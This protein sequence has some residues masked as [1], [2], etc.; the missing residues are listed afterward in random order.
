MK[1]ISLLE[2]CLDAPASQIGGKGTW[3]AKLYS[4][5]VRIPKTICLSTAA[6]SYF[7]KTQGLG[8]KIALELNR[9]EFKDMRWEEIWDA[10]LRIRNLF[11]QSPFPQDLNDELASI[12]DQEFGNTPVA[13]R[14]SAPDEDQQ[15]N[16]FAGLHDSFL[17]ISGVEQIFHSIKKVW[18]SL[19]SDR[20]LLYRKELALS[21]KDSSMAVAI[22]Q[23]IE[24]SVS[25]I[26]FTQDP[27][28]EQKMT[29]EAVHGLNQGLVDGDIEPDRWHL[30]KSTRNIE[31]HT[32]PAK[33]IKQAIA[34]GRS[35]EISNLPQKLQQ[36]PPLGKKEVHTLADEMTRLA[37]LNGQPLDIEW[38]IKDDD[39]YILQSRPI[40]ALR[41]LEGK[42]KDERSWYLSLHRTLENLRNLRNTIEYSML[43]TMA[44]EAEKMAGIDLSRLSPVELADEIRRRQKQSS[45]WTELYWRD[46]IPFAHGIRLFGEVYNDLIV[47]QDSHE[48]VF[49]LRGENMLSL[50]RNATIEELAGML[51]A[52][53]QLFETLK[54]SGI[55]SVA[56]RRFLDLCDQF[57]AEFGSYFSTSAD[58]VH[59]K[60]KLLSKVILEYA[61][62]PASSADTKTKDYK[63]LEDNFL[64][65]LSASNYG[66]EAK[67]FLEMARASY[68]IRDDDNIYL[69]K[70]EEQAG[71]AVTVG[72]RRLEQ[73][74]TVLPHNST[75]EDIANLLYGKTI[76]EPSRIQP[77]PQE[78]LLSPEKLR[79]RQLIGQPASQGV[80]RGIARVIK[81]SIEITDFKASEILVIESIDP[82]MTFF[83]PLASA[84]VEQRGGMLIHG[85]IIAREYGIPCITGIANA[86][87]YIKTGDMLTV[88]GYLGIVTVDRN[89]TGEK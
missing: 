33:R 72:K 43:P 28:D 56:N 29:I 3:L 4:Q 61:Q 44:S 76:E 1:W 86:T 23:L 32:P 36:I 57:L 85:A 83:A 46:C 47:P 59:T 13:L 50:K 22:Q 58:D 64:Q 12:L 84:I 65:K 51:Q 80:A 7:V 38:T 39:I 26:C 52:D 19:W 37:S 10:S 70:I 79:A 24:G 6:Y 11:L 5:D 27:V 49:L 88:D 34:V 45:Y 35:V 73:N 30:T 74:G 31:A 67:D 87:R 17:N 71:F 14:S 20:A 54:R 66:F 15:K 89:A 21:V 40:T 16:S 69:G 18:S 78:S 82:T 60:K 8:E 62:I 63:Q 9:K 55:Q 42:G 2:D 41:S 81:D 75:P 68:R 77:Q 48:F 53:S 25:G